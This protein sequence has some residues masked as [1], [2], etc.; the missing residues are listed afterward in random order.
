VEVGEVPAMK[1]T[2]KD[3]FDL[4]TSLHKSE[5]RK[6]P[7]AA[8]ALL[9]DSFIEFGRSGRIWTK[10]SIVDSMRREE[11]QDQ[12]IVVEDF[13][14]RELASDVVLVTYRALAANQS[15]LRS[16]VWKNIAGKWKMVFHQGTPS[17]KVEVR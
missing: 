10:S 12:G 16:S 9:A 2:Q 6:S 5:T 4:E 8:S 17:S 7:Q 3:F 14:A 1:L 15:T 13:V 11:P